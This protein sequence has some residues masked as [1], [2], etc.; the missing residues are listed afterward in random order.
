[1][2]F[3]FFEMKN[4]VIGTGTAG[5]L[6][7]SH[8]LAYFPSNWQIYSIHDPRKPILGIGESFFPIIF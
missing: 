8:C 4:A 6:S 7:I 3:T 5:I 1:M 2:V